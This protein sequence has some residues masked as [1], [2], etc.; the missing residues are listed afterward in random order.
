MKMMHGPINIRLYIRFASAQPQAYNRS[1][2][3]SHPPPITYVLHTLLALL[4][5]ILS[6]T[7]EFAVDLGSCWNLR[8]APVFVCST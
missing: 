1:K 3:S 8:E 4:S 2:E 5:Q 7:V 6:V